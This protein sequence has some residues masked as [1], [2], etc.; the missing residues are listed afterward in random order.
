MDKAK[1]G[2]LLLPGGSIALL[3]VAMFGI[4]GGPHAATVK[5]GVNIFDKTPYKEQLFHRKHPGM[6]YDASNVYENGDIIKHKNSFQERMCKH[7]QNVAHKHPN[8]ISKKLPLE[9]HH[10][11]YYRV[12][13]FLKKVVDFF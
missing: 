4:G 10:S 3:L 6:C 5:D 8:R 9:E 1:F 12:V 13:E 2:L 11:F 7:H